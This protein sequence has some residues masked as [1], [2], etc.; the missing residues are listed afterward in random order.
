MG[1]LLLAVFCIGLA[2]CAAYSG[3][4]LRPGQSTAT[5]V[6]ATMGRPA[7]AFAEPD[8]GQR[9]AY[10]RGPLGTQTYMADIDGNGRL[11]AVS[12][13]LTDQVFFHI[14]PG[15]HRD[16]VLR[17]IGPPGNSMRFSLSNTY[18]WD[19][20]YVDTWGYTAIFSVTFDAQDRV[21]SK[22]TQRIE[23]PDRGR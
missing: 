8:G 22:I 9:L 18:A 16:E 21:V 13:V 11:S 2:G 17:S 19:W 3:Y 23:R 4:G 12:Q 14:Q 7:M 15:M 20:R 10:P 5:E 6:Q 1:K